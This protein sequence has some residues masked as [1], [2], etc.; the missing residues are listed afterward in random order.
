MLKYG[1]ADAKVGDMFEILFR[2]ELCL[3]KPV[4]DC[5]TVLVRET[6]CRI[7]LDGWVVE[8]AG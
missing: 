6:P 7:L 1:E 3:V 4:D 8:E 5:E 2:A